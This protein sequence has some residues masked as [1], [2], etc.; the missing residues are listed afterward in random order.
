MCQTTEN[1]YS[2]TYVTLKPAKGVKTKGKEKAQKNNLYTDEI[3]LSKG[4]N[5]SAEGY[6]FVGWALNK[7]STKPDFKPG[8]KVSRLVDSG[9]KVKLYSIWEKI[10]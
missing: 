7:E 6:K 4:E 10:N 3:Q 8:E 9:K 2:I 1:K 5:I